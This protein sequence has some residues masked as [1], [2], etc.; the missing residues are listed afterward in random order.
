MLGKED[1]Q[2]P[3]KKVLVVG[4][5]DAC[6]RCTIELRNRD[7]EVLN[8]NSVERMMQLAA[9]GDIS[10]TIFDIHRLNPEGSQPSDYRAGLAALTELFVADTQLGQ[11]FV[12]TGNGAIKNDVLAIMPS[13]HFLVIPTDISIILAGF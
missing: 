12:L 1:N 5:S 7:I 4:N 6:I 11:L 9:A 3:K 8:A 2:I 10:V 13:A